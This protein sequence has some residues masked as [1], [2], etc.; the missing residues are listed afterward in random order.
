MC[1]LRDVCVYGCVCVMTLTY[2]RAFSED[3]VYIELLQNVHTNTSTSKPSGRV[4]GIRSRS[5]RYVYVLYVCIS[6]S[7]VCAGV[8]VCV[9]V[10]VCV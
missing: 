3:V 9:C 10:C 4:V 2:S 7:V 5:W 1:V 6:V 8:C